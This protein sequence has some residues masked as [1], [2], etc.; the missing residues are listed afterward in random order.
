MVP[1][2]EMTAARGR[3]L[4]S[5]ST[6]CEIVVSKLRDGA[7]I[8]LSNGKGEK[9]TMK[10]S[11]KNKA[12]AMDRRTSGKVDFSDAF[13]CVTTAPTHGRINA[14]RIF[15]DASSIEA[16]DADGKMAMTNLVFPT[17]P[18]NKLTVKGGKAVIYEIK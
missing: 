18:Y 2:P 6:K 12:F 3:R 8:A 17:E 14:L 15:V 16:F 7:T 4:A 11:A 1:S 5:P 13:P 9:V 10:Y